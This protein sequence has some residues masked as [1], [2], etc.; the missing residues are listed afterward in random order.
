MIPVLI[1]R[2]PMPSSED[3][4][5]SL[6]PLAFR[7]A[8]EVDQGQDFHH[9][10]DRLIKGIEGLR[11]ESGARPPDETRKPGD[12]IVA[13]KFPASAPI[14]NPP[15]AATHPGRRMQ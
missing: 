13:A 3:L 5:D 8:I 2:T 10:V 7:H 4:P 14:S 9:H 12:A 15:G 11:Q 1:D 6:A